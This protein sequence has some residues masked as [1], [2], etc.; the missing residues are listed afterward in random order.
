MKLLTKSCASRFQAIPLQTMIA[1][2][3][4]HQRKQTEQSLE[5]VIMHGLPG[6]A[7]NMMGEEMAQNTRNLLEAIKA[8]LQEQKQQQLQDNPVTIHY[9]HCDHLGTPLALTDQQGQIVWAARYDPW[10]NIEEEFNPHGI[11]QNIRL[12]GQHHDRETGL[13]YNRHRYYD[14]KLGSYINQDPIG[15]AGGVNSY[16]YPR[17]PLNQI[18][19]IGLQAGA[20]TLPAIGTGATETAGV[21]TAGEI[22]S[23]GLLRALGVLT[24]P[25][26]LSGDT[27]QATDPWGVPI[28]PAASILSYGHAAANGDRTKA[29]YG[30][31]CTPDEFDQLEGEKEKLCNDASSLGGCKGSPDAA[32]QAA[33][34]KCA[35]AREDVM[36]KCFAGGGYGHR[37]AAGQAWNA[38]NNCGRGMK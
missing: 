23:A 9:Y 8:G 29:G 6:Q 12:P 37:E 2:M 33:W 20:A 27:Q 22:I 30:G 14:P 15:L 1:A 36:N 13:Y 26:T 38:A 21:T 18:D 10:G 17:N 19:S 25:L 32:R 28:D 24:L 34:G 4:E 11:E 16:K 3:P 7:L 5:Q 35:R 31:R